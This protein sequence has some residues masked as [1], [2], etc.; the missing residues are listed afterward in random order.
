[1]L[2]RVEVLASTPSSVARSKNTRPRRWPFCAEQR[3]D[4]GMWLL[5]SATHLKYASRGAE[6]AALGR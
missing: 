4:D 3:L 6:A 2:W 1:M 5:R